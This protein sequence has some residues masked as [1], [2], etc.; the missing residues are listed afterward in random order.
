MD[1]KYFVSIIDKCIEELEVGI[2]TLYFTYFSY[3]SSK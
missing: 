2:L 3:F 1:L